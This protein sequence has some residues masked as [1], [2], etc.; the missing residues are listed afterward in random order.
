[1]KTKFPLGI[2]IHIPFCE[3]KCSYCNFASGV[4]PDFTIQPYLKAL[5]EEIHGAGA[6][7][8]ELAIDHGVFESHVVDTIYFGGGTPSLLS[9]D[10]IAATVQIL[11]E[12]FVLAENVE[13]TLEVNPGTVDLEKVQAHVAIGV[14]R[15]SIGM[16]TFQDHLLRRIGRS[17]SVADSIETYQLYRESGIANI[18]LDLILG[19][20]AQSQKEWSDNLEQVQRL[21]PEHISMYI[22]EIH[23]NTHFG[24]VYGP[25]RTSANQESHAAIL[26]E[27]PDDEMVEAFYF[28]AVE[29]FAKGHWRQYEISN[30]A[31]PGFESRHNLKYWTDKPFWGFGCGAY[32]YLDGKRWGNERS[33]G[34]YIELIGQNQHAIV[35]RNE[36]DD[37]ERQEEAFFLGLRLLS[38][39]GLDSFQEKFGFDLRKRFRSNID[40][41]LDAGLIEMSLDSLRLTP[42]GWML[43]N[44][45]FTEFMS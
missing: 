45:V 13:I 27:L 10:R 17:H 38:G 21:N 43:S 23:E 44:E 7:C 5:R 19:L 33:V 12:V 41:L 11:K 39:I 30:F 37:A 9:A 3:S 24:K 28:Q 16:Q 8:R 26:P 42:R 29:S 1:M 35:F 31:R 34:P 40:H 4:F 36:L 18:S 32:S 20:P 22:L 6:I 15:V 2:Y 14:N 25:Q